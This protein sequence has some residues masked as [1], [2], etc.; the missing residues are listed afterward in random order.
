M[1]Y[2]V[3]PLACIFH[4]SRVSFAIPYATITNA[5]LNYLYSP[6]SFPDSW[7]M[8]Q[9]WLRVLSICTSKITYLI[10]VSSGLYAYAQHNYMPSFLEKNFVIFNNISKISWLTWREQN[11]PAWWVKRKA[12]HESAFGGL[13]ADFKW[14][15][16]RCLLGIG[17][18]TVVKMVNTSYLA[19]L[20]TGHRNTLSWSFLACFS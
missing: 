14:C 4:W 18:S 6:L 3:S 15:R 17:F 12:V 19:V 1:L 7:L 16:I 9:V 11:N 10:S 5:S 2:A 20:S 8:T 13:L